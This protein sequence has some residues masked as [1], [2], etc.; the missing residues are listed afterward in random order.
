MA[1]AAPIQL[2]DSYFLIEP[3]ESCGE[4]KPADGDFSDEIGARLVG[5]SRFSL[6]PFIIA[7]GAG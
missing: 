3:I 4:K 5:P 2:Y 7:S 6:I 1:A